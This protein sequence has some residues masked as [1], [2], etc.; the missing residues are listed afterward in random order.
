MIVYHLKNNYN[1]YIYCN[2]FF[3]EDFGGI[4]GGFWSILEEIFKLLIYLYTFYHN[5]YNI[6]IFLIQF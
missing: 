5:F 4:F 2:K 1:K 3:S 6:L